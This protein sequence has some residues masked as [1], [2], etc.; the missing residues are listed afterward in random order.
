MIYTN[1]NIIIKIS[2]MKGKRINFVII[3]DKLIL[4]SIFNTL[5]K[6]KSV[7]VKYSNIKTNKATF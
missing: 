2:N 6:Y 7:F 1:I 5:K 3:R 4:N